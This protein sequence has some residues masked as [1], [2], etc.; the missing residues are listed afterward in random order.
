MSETCKW[1]YVPDIGEEPGTTSCD[2]SAEY[3]TCNFDGGVCAEH[4]CRCSK[5]LAQ[6]PPSLPKPTAS[7]EEALSE[8]LMLLE[9]KFE[10]HP[11]C[12]IEGCPGI[13]EWV[14]PLFGSCDDD[15]EAHY[16]C[17]QHEPCD[18]PHSIMSVAK[19]RHWDADVVLWLH[20]NKG[21]VNGGTK[22]E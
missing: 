10:H 18:E 4:R 14:R 16:Y 11:S 17:A 6:P 19:Y 12:H 5:P 21:L 15:P 8:V 2:K 3:T 20:K 13:V 1:F 9:R 7:V 22:K